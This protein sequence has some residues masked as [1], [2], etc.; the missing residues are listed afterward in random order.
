MAKSKSPIGG[1]EDTERG[2]INSI[3]L[4]LGFKMFKFKNEWGYFIPLIFV[5]EKNQT[6]FSPCSAALHFYSSR[7]EDPLAGVNLLV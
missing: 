4:V 5:I 6:A 7:C 3:K 1:H 2:S